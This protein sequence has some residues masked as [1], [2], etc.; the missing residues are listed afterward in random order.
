MGY[1]ISLPIHLWVPEFKLD[2]FVETG[3]WLGAGVACARCFVDLQEFHSIDINEEFYRH[4]QKMFGFDP[5]VHLYHGKSV[6]VL[7][8]VLAQSSL[9][10]RRI[11]FWLDAHLPE[12]YGLEETTEE[13]IQLP[14][15][16]EL[17]IILGMRP[18]ND[19]LIIIDDWR[20]YEDGEYEHGRL[21][22][23]PYADGKFVEEIV[24]DRY[25]ISKAIWQTGFLILSP[26]S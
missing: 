24:G 18:R 8:N 6:D 12:I 26:K 16:K 5:S 7:P 3:T 19:D 17:E 23:R 25:N 9:I 15:K 10:N 20:M 2:A 22:A 13:E 1:F 4:G 14:L 11:L 21:P